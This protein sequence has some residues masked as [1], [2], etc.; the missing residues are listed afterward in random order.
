[1]PTSTRSV[2]PPQTPRK[3]PP[4]SPSGG[5]DNREMRVVIEALIR[6]HKFTVSLLEKVL[7]QGK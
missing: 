4:P 5:D 2:L 6:G 3:V 7:E 1:M